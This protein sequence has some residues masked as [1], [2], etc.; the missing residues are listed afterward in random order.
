MPEP[1]TELPLRRDTE[2]RRA[3][4][5]LI[6][7][8]MDGQVWGIDAAE[9]PSG[10]RP[11]QEHIYRRAKD[12]GVHVITRMKNGRLFVQ[13]VETPEPRPTTARGAHA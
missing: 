1:V 7:R 10:I 11:F 4:D 6:A 12:M 13:K 8:I 3:Y 9:T 2:V 5:M